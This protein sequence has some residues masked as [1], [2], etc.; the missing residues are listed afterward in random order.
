VFGVDIKREREV[1]RGREGVE[2]CYLKNMCIF[3][4]VWF[5]FYLGRGIRHSKKEWTKTIF[6]ER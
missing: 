5:K 3:L 2:T 1:E 4:A 6:S